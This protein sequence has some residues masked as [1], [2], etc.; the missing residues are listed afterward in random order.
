MR[1][2][3]YHFYKDAKDTRNLQINNKIIFS[4]KQVYPNHDMR[5]AF[6]LAYCCMVIMEK[7][8]WQRMQ[9][10]GMGFFFY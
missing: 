8:N 6:S 2:R 7:S 3:Y 5:F 9:L 4:F 10:S 1:V